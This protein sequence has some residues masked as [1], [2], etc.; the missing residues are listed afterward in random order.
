VDTS[1]ELASIKAV[2]SALNRASLDSSMTHAE[3][4][5]V[6]RVGSNP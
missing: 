3:P 1:I 2:I 4:A 5:E 6:G